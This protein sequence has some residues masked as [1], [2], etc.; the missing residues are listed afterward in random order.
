MVEGPHEPSETCDS[1][2]QHNSPFLTYLVSIMEKQNKNNR[3][4]RIHRLRVMN[5]D[6]KK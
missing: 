4:P 2:V 3:P 6:S 1:L 5:V